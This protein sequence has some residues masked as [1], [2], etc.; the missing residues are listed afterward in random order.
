MPLPSVNELL[1]QVN[2]VGYATPAKYLVYVYRSQLNVTSSDMNS[3][4]ANLMINCENTDFP[5]LGVMTFDRRY[6]GLTRKLPYGTVYP[7]IAM[8]FYCSQDHR[9]RKFFEEWYNQIIDRTSQNVAFYDDYIS[10][11]QI[12]NYDNSGIE[13]LYGELYEAY[14]IGISSLN[15][16]Y[17][18]ESSIIRFS[19]DFAYKQ[20]QIIDRTKIYK[21]ELPEIP[22]IS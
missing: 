2:N 1:Y 10:T 14:P 21:T 4:A 9:E 13:A 18:N 16:S 12:F 11:I 17:S 22:G 6:Y 15:F 19:V 3:K 7:P 5:G 20:Y 8:S